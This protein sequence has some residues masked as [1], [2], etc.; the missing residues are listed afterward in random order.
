LRIGDTEIELKEVDV[1]IGKTTAWLDGRVPT[2]SELINAEFDVRVAGPNLGRAARAF[3]IRNLPALPFSFEGSMT[4]EGQAYSIDDLT[5]MIGG[6]DVSGDFRLEIGPRARLSGRLESN[7]LNL[8]ELRGRD[9]DTDDTDESNDDTVVHDRLIP[10]TPLRYR[11]LDIAD[12][13]LTVRMRHLV[14]NYFDVGDVE[15]E[16]FIDS[17]ELHVE[18]GRVSLRNGGTMTAALGL[19]RTGD[20][21]ADVQISVI[22]EQFRLRPPIDGDGNPINS[23]P[24]DLNL[25][26]AGSG[27]TVRELAASA[28]GSISLRLG[29]GD[30]DNDFSGY[31]MRDMVAQ[32]FAAI[33]PLTKK[34]KYTHLN[35]AFFEID[36]VDGVAKSRALGL[37][38]NEL[39]VASVG[40]VNLATEALDLSFRIKQREGVGISITGVVNPYIKVGG[41]LASPALEIDKKRGFFAGTIAA[42]TG[43]LSILAQ[44]VWDR[45]LSEDNY[46]QAVIDALDSGELPVW[47]GE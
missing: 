17:D 8:T 21:S 39:V 29:E 41:T 9:D 15:L 7:N 23:S 36:I 44:G 31:V 38:T 24:A 32:V 33:N 30:I 3:N 25:A 4:R 22:A 42:L 45:Y 46:C 1:R 10:D 47:E 26:L 40:T 34:S 35:C 19:V 12:I 6:N 2:G 5:A 13:D 28:D 11:V 43:G 18:T 27:A 20:E 37:Q 16:V 14:T